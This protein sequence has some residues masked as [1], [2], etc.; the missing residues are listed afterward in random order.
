MDKAKIME[1]INKLK[2]KESEVESFIRPP[3]E[4]GEA[5][6]LY[7]NDKKNMFRAIIFDPDTRIN[8]DE[9]SLD[10]VDQAYSFIIQTLDG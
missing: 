8:Y 6:K 7:Y 1:K 2:N 10:D 4:F 5:V 3:E 9:K